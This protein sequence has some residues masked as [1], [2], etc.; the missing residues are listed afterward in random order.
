[1]DTDTLQHITTLHRLDI[2]LADKEFGNDIMWQI[3]E[4]EFAK[5]KDLPLLFIMVI[6][7]GGW[8]LQY[9]KDGTIVGTANDCA[10]LSE[11]ARRYKADSHNCKTVWLPAIWR[12]EFYS[13]ITRAILAAKYVVDD[14]LNGRTSAQYQREGPHP[15]KGPR[16][17]PEKF[18]VVGWINQTN[19]Q[20]TSVILYSYLNVVLTDNEAIV[21]ARDYLKENNILKG[22][23]LDQ[24]DF[25]H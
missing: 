7:H 9:A 18:R 22:C 1:M 24:P 11:K 14:A 20:P 25:I 16:P 21:L 10:V 17:L 23:D 8:W 4:R 19:L 5:H 15:L 2:H 12:Q 13:S 3:A 6:E